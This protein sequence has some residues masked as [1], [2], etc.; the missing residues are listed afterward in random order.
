MRQMPRHAFYAF[1]R[2]VPAQKQLNALSSHDNAVN[3][4]ALTPL[5]PNPQKRMSRHLFIIYGHFNES[6][7]ENL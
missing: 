2:K 3:W 7:D 5:T 6:T 4:F 1:G